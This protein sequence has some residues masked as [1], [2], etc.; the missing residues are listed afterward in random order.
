MDNQQKVDA[1]LNLANK[2]QESK[3]GKLKIFLGYAPGVGKSYAMLNNARAL[4][5]DN[6][7]VVVGLLVS[8][9]RADTQALLEGLEIMPLKKVTYRGRVFEELDIDA[10]KARRPDVVIIDEL[11]HSNLPTSRNKKRYI[12]IEELLDEG[13]SVYTAINIQHIASLSYEVT[14]LT[15]ANVNEIVPNDFIQSADELVVVDVSPEELIKRLKQGKVYKSDAID[16][17][18]ERYFQYTNLTILR[19]YTFRMAANHVGQDIQQYRKLYQ[20]GSA[21]ATSPY[22]LVCCGY[23]EATPSLLRKGKLL[24]T[25]L[26]ARLIAVFVQKPNKV[27]TKLN[28]SVIRRY[29]MLASSLGYNIDHILGDKLSDSILEYARTIGATDLVIGKSIRSKWKDKLFGSVV[30]DII[31]N[32]NGMQVHIVSINKKEHKIQEQPRHSKIKPKDLVVDVIKSALITAVSGIFIFFSLSIAGLVSQTLC[33]LM[34]LAACAYRYGLI[35]SIISSLVGLILYIYLYLEPNFVFH[36]SSLA[37]IITFTFFMTIVIFSSHVILR[38]KRAFTLLKERENNISVLYRFTKM[39][40]EKSLDKDL[41]SVFLPALEEYFKCDFVFLSVSGSELDS[42]AFPQHP[43]FNQ[44]ELAAAKWSFKYK[45]SCGKGTNTFAGLDWAVEPLVIENRVLGVIAIYLSSELAVER[46]TTDSV[47]L[48]SM[49]SHISHILLKRNLEKEE[50]KSLLLDEQRRLQKSMLSSVSHD[51]KTPLASIM[52][53]LSSIKSYKDS[54]NPEQQGELLDLALTES[55]RLD[56][57]IDNI[58]QMLKV[59]SGKLSLNSQIVNS[60]LF[61]TEIKETCARVYNKQKFKFIVPKEPFDIELDPVLFQQVILNLIDN[62]VKFTCD[63]E[64]EIIITLKRKKAAF[65]LFEVQ[66]KGIGLRE[67]DMEKIFTIFHRIEKRDSYTHGNGLGLAICKG[68]V[69]AHNGKIRVY[70]DGEGKGSVFKI[71]LPL[72]SSVK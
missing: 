62:A 7:D 72:K 47:I 48:S 69:A 58:I 59:D 17:A 14:Q 9:G 30:Y 37:G 57:Y 35:P 18:L 5:K 46:I 22:V 55:K 60:N 4:Q 67:S 13:I 52:G 28:F 49:L 21:I 66:D 39:F 36:I 12:D 54:F 42:A 64:K 53:A 24:A 44:K 41:R 71:T 16:R 26:N 25:T 20:H 56:S 51:L 38:T 33:F 34:V 29:K 8:H 50:K 2:S 19:D 11:P 68:I 43:N 15:Q 10:I 32:N 63:F 45:D 61:L 6:K 70:S 31:R 1:L 65:C 3:K 40:N 23:D 27:A